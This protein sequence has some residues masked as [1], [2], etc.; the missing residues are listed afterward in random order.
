MPPKIIRLSIEKLKI[1]TVL[2]KVALHILFIPSSLPPPNFGLQ[3]VKPPTKY[4][5]FTLRL[6]LYT[7]SFQP[8]IMALRSTRASIQ[9]G[10]SN[11]ATLRLREISSAITMIILVVIYLFVDIPT[12]IMLN[13]MLIYNY[14][15]PSLAAGTGIIFDIEHFVQVCSSLICSMK[16]EYNTIQYNMIIGILVLCFILYIRNSA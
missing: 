6:C 9:A 5:L 11:N 14:L 13:V 12:V 8:R 10:Q 3:T 15:V 1:V 16:T 7:L 4:F 2:L